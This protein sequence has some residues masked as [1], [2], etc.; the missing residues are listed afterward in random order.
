[1]ACLARLTTNACLQG[2]F[3]AHVFPGE[4]LE[5][6][7]WVTSS[8]TVVFQTKVLGRNVIVLKAG[9]VT[10]REGALKPP[11]RAAQ[12]Q[13]HQGADASGGLSQGQR[14]RPQLAD[15]PSPDAGPGSL[16]GS[17]SAEAESRLPASKL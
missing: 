9:G 17:A 12:R 4:T 13:Q 11:Q 15:I 3:A 6:Q 2:R 16:A 14:S 5:T 7:M 10:F 8:T 1:M